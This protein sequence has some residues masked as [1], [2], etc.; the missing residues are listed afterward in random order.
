MT[1]RN[2]SF[3]V[4]ALSLAMMVVYALPASAATI[5][6]SPLSSFANELLQS[7]VEL[8]A[9]VIVGATAWAAKKWFGLQVDEKQRE[10]LH[11]AIERGIGSALDAIAKKVDGN[12]TIQIDSKVVALV[13]N[14]V[15]KMSPDAVSYFGLTPDKLAE[16]IKAKLGGLSL[17]MDSSETQDAASA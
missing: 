3:V 1:S 2:S 17:L 11:G 16:L 12:S 5:D 14:Y 9:A 10:A 6:F 15:I 13:A 7:L 8:L 4:V